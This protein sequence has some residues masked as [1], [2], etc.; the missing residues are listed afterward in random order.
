MATDT[1]SGGSVVPSGERVLTGVNYLVYALAFLLAA[2][3]AVVGSVAIIAQLKGTWH[4]SIHL[5]S[6]I[7]YVG[8]F[9]WWVLAVLVPL[10]VVRFLGRWYVRD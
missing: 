9:V 5:E 4:W 7:S 1:S 3:L 6:T 8:L 2:S 10:S